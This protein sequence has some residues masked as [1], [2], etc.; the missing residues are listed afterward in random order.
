MKRVVGVVVF[1]A[2]AG[3]CA[4]DG[5]VPVLTGDAERGRQVA[6][7]NGCAVCHGRHGQG[8]PGGDLVGLWGSEVELSDGTSVTADAEY[9][10]RAIVDPDAD[11][12]AG[13]GIRMPTV[14]LSDEQVAAMLIWI[15]ALA[16][17]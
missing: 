14:E 7:D 13:S 10:R 6:E 15:E 5:T 12:V 8:G 11:I 16:D 17:E 2:V 3:A 9:V 1:A 4:S